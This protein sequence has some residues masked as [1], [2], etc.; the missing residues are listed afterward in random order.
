MTRG[1]KTNQNSKYIHILRAMRE[2]DTVYLPLLHPR[3][4]ELLRIAAKKCGGN[5]ATDLFL[6]TAG[7][8]VSA[9]Y[10]VRVTMNIVCCTKKR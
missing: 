7:T 9:R 1:A 3:M 4:P 2:G 6:A 5:C 8:P 10:V